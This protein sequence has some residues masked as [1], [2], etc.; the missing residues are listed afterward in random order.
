M[1]SQWDRLYDELDIT[2]HLKVMH[3]NTFGEIQLTHMMT[4]KMMKQKRGVIVHISSFFGYFSSLGL[5][6]VYAPTKAFVNAFV[7]NL[8]AETKS[9]KDIHH[10]LVTPFFVVTKMTD[11]VVKPSKVTPDA[12]TFVSS[13]IRQL[14]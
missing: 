13:A 14:V 6:S 2:E 3:T 8:Q 12:T 11:K 9:C 5:I 7:E 10:Q 1:S 4:R